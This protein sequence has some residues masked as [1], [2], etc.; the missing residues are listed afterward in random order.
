VAYTDALLGVKDAGV[1]AVM[2]IGLGF[3]SE[4]VFVADIVPLPL[5]DAVKVTV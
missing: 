3:A 5:A 1:A 2:A 4:P